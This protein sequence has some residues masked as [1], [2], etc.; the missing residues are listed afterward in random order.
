MVKI[1][2]KKDYKDEYL[3]CSSCLCN[4]SDTTI[5]RITIGKT[6]R[7]T[8]T[9]KLCANCLKELQTKIMEI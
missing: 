4:N 9:L 5:Y 7:Q 6:D 8:I 3:Q 2:N 1:E